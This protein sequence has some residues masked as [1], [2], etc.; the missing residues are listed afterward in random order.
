MSVM[1]RRMLQKTRKTPWR[2]AL[3]EA[4]SRRVAR[5]TRPTRPPARTPAPQTAATAKQVSLYTT[6][7]T[8]SNTNVTDSLR[9]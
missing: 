2:R 1:I 5:R 3:G 9:L 4:S 7:P 8:S 6:L